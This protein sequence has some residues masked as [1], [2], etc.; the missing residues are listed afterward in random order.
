[1]KKFIAI[2]IMIIFTFGVSYAE[3]DSAFLDSFLQLSEGDELDFSLKCKLNSLYPYDD[4]QTKVYNRALNNFKLNFSSINGEDRQYYLSSLSFADSNIFSNVELK[5]GEKQ[6]ILNTLL[7]GTVFSSSEQK[8]IFDIFNIENP[9]ND[10]EHFTSEKS[11][12]DLDYIVNNIDQ[13]EK[14]KRVSF[15]VKGFQDP[16]E[17]SITDIGK[18]NFEQY[19]Q[20]IHTIALIGFDEEYSNSLNIEFDNRYSL[21]TLYDKEGRAI[22][23]RLKGGV[24]LDGQK[25]E[26][27]TTIDFTH[28]LSRVYIK[29]KF[30]NSNTK[31]IATEL[32]MDQKSGENNSYFEIKDKN[33][34]LTD[35]KESNI[36]SDIGQNQNTMRGSYKHFSSVENGESISSKLIELTPDITI[37]KSEKKKYVRGNIG[38]KYT[39]NDILKIDLQAQFGNADDL[40][41]AYDIAGIFDVAIKNGGIEQNPD[42]F[43][44]DS[45]EARIVNLDEYNQEIFK[46]L[47]EDLKTQFSAK[48]LRVMLA[49]E[50]H[51][52]YILSYGMQPEDWQEFLEYYKSLEE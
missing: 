26:I 5:Y 23:V 33:Y 45:E 28:D 30:K 50:D 24:S 13:G 8:N 29:N 42:Y 47:Q 16:Y 7:Q 40:Q 17:Q 11:I 41:K 20:I 12:S 34:K 38:L 3:V 46:S 51:S 10:K 52:D 49:Q 37:E 25:Y 48:T 2:L 18:N 14:K 22:G 9:F 6:Y 44:G 4:S 43:K 32:G 1:M 36:I 39:D 27:N 19:E 21:R 35:N 15:A 31:Y